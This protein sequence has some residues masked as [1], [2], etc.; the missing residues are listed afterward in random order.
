MSRYREKTCPQCATVH[1]KRGPYCSRSCGN[2]R[3][4]TEERKEHQRTVMTTVMNAPDKAEHRAH[5]GDIL[6]HKQKQL[7]NKDDLDLQELS[8]EDLF[9][10]PV[11]RTLPD[12]QFVAGGDLWT[13]V[14]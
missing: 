6:R 3:D 2:S 13:D 4:H 10:Q 7:V 11:V 8:Y 1:H 12:G 14:D 5:A 9:V